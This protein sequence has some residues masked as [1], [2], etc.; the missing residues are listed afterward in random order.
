MVPREDLHVCVW[1]DL[2]RHQ[3]GYIV[4]T[5]AI[6]PRASLSQLSKLWVVSR[7]KV[8]G[9]VASYIRMKFGK[10]ESTVFLYTILYLCSCMHC[11]TSVSHTIITSS[12]S[13]CF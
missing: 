1:K 3:R 8:C 12:G 6:L 7:F 11:T 5:Q 2:T 4:P 10:H 9:R 13:G